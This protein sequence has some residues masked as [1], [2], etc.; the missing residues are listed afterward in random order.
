MI[1]AFSSG[2]RFFVSS[3]KG[4]RASRWSRSISPQTLLEEE[5]ERNA[6]KKRKKTKNRFRLHDTGLVGCVHKKIVCTRKYTLTL[7]RSKSSLGSKERRKEGKEKGRQ[8]ER[9]ERRKEEKLLDS[10]HDFDWFKQ[11]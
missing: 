2:A 11:N 1:L 5:E 6:K 9:K 3:S 7:R 4:S 8:G 10:E